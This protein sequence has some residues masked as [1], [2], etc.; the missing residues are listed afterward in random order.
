MSKCVTGMVMKK[1]TSFGCPGDGSCPVWMGWSSSMVRTLDG[2]QQIATYPK[3]CQHAIVRDWGPF[4]VKV[5]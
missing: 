4:M 5:L 1:L 2:T 3:Q